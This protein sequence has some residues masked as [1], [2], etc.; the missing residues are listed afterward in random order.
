MRR[1]IILVLLV[2]VSPAYSFGRMNKDLMKARYYYAHYQFH[3]AIPYF[4]KVADSLRDPEVFAEAGDCFRMTGSLQKSADYYA[5]AMKI[6]GRKDQTALKYGQVLMQLAQYESAEKW[7]KEYQ[8]AKKGDKRAANLIAGCEE[9]KKNQSMIPSGFATLAPFNTNGADFAPAWWRGNLVFTSDTALNPNKKVD[10]WSGNA[11]L[12][13]YT[14]ACD[15]QGKA[16]GPLAEV[17]NAK[18]INIKYHDGPA[19]FSPDGKTM[20]FTRSRYSNGLFRAK[21]VANKDSI[22]LLEIMIA[23]DYDSVTK[24][25]QKVS[26]FQ[27][28]SREYS[29]AHPTLSQNGKTMVF[30]S[31][32]PGGVGGSDLYICTKTGDNEW[33]KPASIGYSINTEGEELFPWLADD[34]TLYF[35][36]DGH[37]GMGGL[38]IYKAIWDAESGKFGAPENVSAPVN[39]SYDD[40]SLALFADGHSSWFS[41]NRPARAGGDNIYYYKREMV[42]M[43]L[44]AKD[45]ATNEPLIGVKINLKTGTD[46]R[47]TI[48]D[49]KGHLFTQLFA[50]SQYEVELSK[51]DFITRKFSFN[52]TSTKELDT[53]IKSIQLARKA[54]MYPT[55]TAVPP[56]PTKYTEIIG[57]PKLDKIYT[58][59]TVPFDYD[60]YAILSNARPCLDSLAAFMKS[61]PTLR[62]EVRAHTDCR[63]KVPGYNLALSK[64]RAM[65]VVNY[66]KSKGISATRLSKL[67]LAS[68]E[69]RIPCPLCEKCTEDQHYQNRIMDFRVLKN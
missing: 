64:K 1:I 13:L 43:N 3:E 40:I 50:R 62:I 63:E 57:K 52:T 41:S 19:T 45:S 5:K 22:V 61:N 67:G 51:D 25:F 66:L 30:V 27:Y 42:F 44:S 9:A 46:Q 17:T 8:K 39:S 20:Y 37:K 38:D 2:M 24:D 36:S 12:N 49:N 15:S 11:Y 48:T 29:V 7:L 21:A 33:T 32:M 69:P 18:N 16:N 55:D 34:N 4:V 23:S 47:D 54:P 6:P 60:Q 59:G 68:T 14:I 58:I 53:I 56:P 28:N 35:S 31:N 26:P 65:A 10:K